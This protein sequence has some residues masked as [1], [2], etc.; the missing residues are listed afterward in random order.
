[1]TRILLITAFLF[2]SQSTMASDVVDFFDRL[3]GK[4]ELNHGEITNIDARDNSTHQKITVLTSSIEKTS[5]KEWKFV[6]HYCVEQDCVDTT[7]SYILEN[8]EDLF[9]V[10][11]QGR[12]ELVIVNSAPGHLNFLLRNEGSYALTDCKIKGQEMTQEGFTMNADSTQSEIKISL[13]KLE[14]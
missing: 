12:S 7:Y 10:T 9:L 2:V 3:Q 8:E 13:K 14:L 6:E 1:M 11:E 4:W 5:T